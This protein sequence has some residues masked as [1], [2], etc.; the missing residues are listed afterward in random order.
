MNKDSFQKMA[1]LATMLASADGQ[2]IDKI[3][4]KKT[5]RKPKNKT[6]P[7]GVKYFYFSQIGEVFLEKNDLIVFSCVARNEENARRKFNNFRFN[8]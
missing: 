7:K 8:Q 6:I 4:G 1:M 5:P 2:S 3:V